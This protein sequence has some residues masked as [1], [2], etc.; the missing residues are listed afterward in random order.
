MIIEDDDDD[1]AMEDEEALGL[2]HASVGGSAGSQGKGRKTG[3]TTRGL[4]KED[5]DD[6]DWNP[7]ASSKSSRKD[8]GRQ[9]SSSGEG[10]RG[11]GKGQGAKDRV[12]SLGS[13][14]QELIES[15]LLRR[16]RVTTGPSEAV[17][18]RRRAKGFPA[19]VPAPSPVASPTGGTVAGVK[20]AGG[21]ANGKGKKDKPKTASPKGRVTQPDTS[22]LQAESQT[23]LSQALPELPQDKDQDVIMGG[24]ED[25]GSGEDKQSIQL[26]MLNRAGG[27][28]TS[29]HAGDTTGTGGGLSS[30]LRSRGGFLDSPSASPLKVPPFLGLTV[31][32]T[33]AAES[34][35]RTLL[36]SDGGGSLASPTLAEKEKDNEGEHAEKKVKP[37]YDPSQFGP[38]SSLSTLGQSGISSASVRTGSVQQQLTPLPFG[39]PPP[40]QHQ[41]LQPQQAQSQPQQQTPL[42]PPP[43]V[44]PSTLDLLKAAAQAATPALSIPPFG[45]FSVPPEALQM[46]FG[47]THPNP[48]EALQIPFGT[49]H[50]GP[51]LTFETLAALQ[52]SAPSP[53]HHPGS[54]PPNL[55]AQV[56]AS[57][58]GGLGGV[59]WPPLHSSSNLNPPP[60]VQQRGRSQTPISSPGQTQCFAASGSQSKEDKG[61]QIGDWLQKHNRWD[62]EAVPLDRRC[63]VC[64]DG[65]IAARKTI[66]VPACRACKENWETLRKAANDKN[67]ML[68]ADLFPFVE[69]FVGAHARRRDRGV[70]QGWEARSMNDL[71]H[72]GQRENWFGKTL[73]RRE[74]EERALR[75]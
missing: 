28:H 59:Q 74:K 25:S 17:V 34:L 40:T 19:E 21:K 70:P 14:T 61:P 35:K 50:S 48:A 38:S 49:S 30:T 12:S 33:M 65:T 18:P 6:E 10:V 32:T 3:G 69:Q 54:L 37:L 1:D 5:E 11:A 53:L 7:S 4:P 45:P 44:N 58:Q 23:A 66:G 73:S 8:K 41:P 64:N 68:D 62:G 63:L 51:A 22:F 31:D 27:T 16:G 43:G 24:S 72:E 42:F 36:T 47:A 9:Q 46:P 75:G 15:A 2:Q 26:S 67:R 60:G 20:Q 55:S 13:S 71:F 56:A 57:L 29:L 39:S 52:N